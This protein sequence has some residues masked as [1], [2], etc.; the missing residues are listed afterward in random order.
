MLFRQV[1]VLLGGAA[2]LTLAVACGGDGP[3][4]A[5]TPAA[6]VSPDSVSSDLAHAEDP[7]AEER[8]LFISAGC[9]AC[10]GQDGEG[11]SI[12]PALAGHNEE[13]VRRQVRAPVGVMPA[14]SAIQIG[15]TDLE[16][17][18]HFVESLAPG[19][20]HQEPA[21]MGHLV[22]MHRQ[23]ALLALTAENAAEAEHHVRH[24]CRP[25]AIMGHVR[26][27]ENPRV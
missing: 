15:D 12:A 23:M 7:V 8:E 13:Q 3:S 4:S 20:A 21:E 19:D 25:S 18:A 16:K 17:I 11:T 22:A 5:P 10:H 2:G 24:Y 1:F 27:V 9:A 26:G 6:T 14:F